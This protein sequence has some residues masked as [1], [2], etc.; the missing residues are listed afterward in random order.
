[1]K[2]IKNENY[3]ERSLIKRIFNDL[4]LNYNQKF[5][6]NSVFLFKELYNI[7]CE[8]LD[9]SGSLRI[10][11]DD[12]KGYNVNLCINDN[13]RD[14]KARY[15][16]LGIEPS[17]TTLINQNIKLQNELLTITLYDGSPFIEDNNKEYRFRKINEIQEDARES[18]LII[19]E[20]L[21]QLHPFLFDLY[22]M[23]YI[24]KDETKFVR[25]CYD[26]VMIILMNN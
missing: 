20:N 12:I 11:K 24:I 9:K 6:L 22:N 3:K 23:N 1:M 4:N 19:I 16:L 5:K 7:V 18:K 17:L 26:Y 14:I 8:R 2:K 15:L 10:N 13:I 21:N 25:I